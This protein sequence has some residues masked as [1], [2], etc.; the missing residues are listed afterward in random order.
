MSDFQIADFEFNFILSL[1]YLINKF[2]LHALESVSIKLR[3]PRTMSVV[4]TK[5]YI[6]LVRL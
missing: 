1:N 5:T 3:L 2:P 6:V 4:M